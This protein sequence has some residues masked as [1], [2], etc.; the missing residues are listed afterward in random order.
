VKKETLKGSAYVLTQDVA[1]YESWGIREIN[2]CQKALAALAVKTWPSQ[3]NSNIPNRALPEGTGQSLSS[4]DML[5]GSP[6]GPFQI[7][8]G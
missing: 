1:Q 5:R 4:G 7:L 8:A 3:P 2:E 6:D